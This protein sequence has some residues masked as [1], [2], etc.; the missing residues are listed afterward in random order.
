MVVQN[1][2]GAAAGWLDTLWGG[3]VLFVPKLILSIVLLALGSIVASGLGAV[4]Q[5]IFEAVKL[6]HL[7]ERAGLA[8]YFERAGI[9]LRG[10]YF[11]GKLTF[12]F[13]LI[14]F[15]L[16]ASDSLGLYALSE[17]LRSVLAYV[18]NVIAAVLIMLASVVVGGFL[19]KVV[20]A[21]VMSA[22]L[23]AAQFLGTLTWWA[24]V[25][26]GLVTALFQL[27]VAPDLIKNIVTA[28]VAMLALAGGLAFGLGGKEYASHLIN[29]LREHTGSK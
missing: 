4:V 2:A 22:K 17:F 29:K 15:L 23:H 18:P 6:D 25:I 3:F 16:A 1:L 7:L 14:A 19:R 10:A 27:K 11:L 8:P 20:V 26:F 12:W 5:R 28:F 24:V 9:K 13:L 21:S